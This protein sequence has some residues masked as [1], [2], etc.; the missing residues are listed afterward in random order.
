MLPWCARPKVFRIDKLFNYLFVWG[1]IDEDLD[2]KNMYVST[3]RSTAVSAMRNRCSVSERSA[4]A[5]R[6]A[7]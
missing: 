2:R 3:K 7:S 4:S 1:A 6:G 5:S